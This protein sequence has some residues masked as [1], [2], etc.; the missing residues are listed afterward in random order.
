M[1]GADRLARAFPALLALVALIALLLRAWGLASEPASADDLGCGA[2]AVSFVEH[3]RIGPVEWHHPH[4]RDLLVW[5]SVG[6]AGPTKVGLALAS[7]LLGVVAIPVVGLLGRA[8]AGTAVGL[9]AAVLLAIDPIHVGYSRQAVQESYPLL[10]G[11]LGALLTL[12]HA[13]DG[14]P[15]WLLAAGAAFGLGAASKWSVVF[16]ALAALAWTAA[17]AVRRAE[18]R[19]DAAA[20]VALAVA[21]LAI[22]PACLYLLT[23]TPWLVGGRDLADLARLHVA[24][25]REAVGHGGY[26]AADLALQHR[27]ALWFVE[28]VA[29]AGF[30]IGPRG[31]IAFVYLTNPLVWLAVLPAAAFA[32]RD[33]WR[34]EG[35][36]LAFVLALFAA[37]YLPFAVA[38]RPI[39]IHS[40]LGALPFAIILVAALVVRTAERLSWPRAAVAAY[41]A[42]AALASAPLYALATG[43]AL[44]SPLLRGIAERYRPAPELER[45]PAGR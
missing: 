21:A 11:A 34:G 20:R 16:P 3:A 19:R 38:S 40:A 23:W 30:A 7:L 22:L 45:G 4:L 42:A 41:L 9:L 17:R 6:I 2:S 32:A 44:E 29:Y 37:A 18:T 39:W 31:P 15:S 43:A 24:M 36:D 25:A 13:R 8:V 26:N 12:R 35:G 10:F 28:P 5:A 1:T 33:S 27:A 14:R